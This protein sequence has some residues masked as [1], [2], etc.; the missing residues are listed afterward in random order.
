LVLL[1]ICRQALFMQVFF[2]RQ[3]RERLQKEE[4]LP[5]P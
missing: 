2:S 3:S 4:F 1:Q 5:L